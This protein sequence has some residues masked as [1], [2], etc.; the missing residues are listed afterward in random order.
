MSV[1]NVHICM[2]FQQLASLVAISS[3]SN[4]ESS[5]CS[6]ADALTE[7]SLKFLFW[8]ICLEPPNSWVSCLLLEFLETNSTVSLMITRNENLGFSILNCFPNGLL[9]DFLSQGKPFVGQTHI[10]FGTL[11]RQRVRTHVYPLSLEHYSCGNIS[12]KFGN[13]LEFWKIN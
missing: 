3:R 11:E 6:L 8:Q 5:G 2:H 12:R 7:K 13:S 4:Y 10:L 9:S 1:R